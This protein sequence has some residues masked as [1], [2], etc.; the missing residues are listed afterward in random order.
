MNEKEKLIEK[1]YDSFRNVKLEDG[2][3]LWEGKGLDDY[4]TREELKELKKKDIKDDWNKIPL[5]DLY[6]CSSALSYFDAKGMRFHLPQF[7]LF[8]LGVFEKE[9]ND[10]KWELDSLYEPD[11]FFHLTHELQREYTKQRFSSLDKV[12]IECVIDYLKLQIE[13]KKEYLKEFGVIWD[14]KEIKEVKEV[15]NTWKAKLK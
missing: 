10:K 7:L 9:Q 8:D 4:A 1:V 12:Q 5:K 2:I 11:I 6:D 14:T 3:W 15:V 13:E